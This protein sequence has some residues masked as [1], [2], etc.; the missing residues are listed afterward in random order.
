MDYF[1][2]DTI[3]FCCLD[4]LIFLIL[5]LEIIYPSKRHLVMTAVIADCPS[6]TRYKL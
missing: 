5:R 3:V 2:E 6:V 1:V 4:L